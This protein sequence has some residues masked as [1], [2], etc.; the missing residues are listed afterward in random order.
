MSASERAMVYVVRHGE[1]EWSRTGRH[2]GRSDVVLTPHG[3]EQASAIGQ[4]LAGISFDTVLTS[5][6]ARAKETCRTA[7]Y[8]GEAQE[9]E[10]LVEWDY[11]D[12]EG[13]TTD[14]IRRSVPGWTLFD[15]GVIGGESPADVGR[16][17]DRVIAVL[18]ERDGDSLCFAHAHVLRVFAARWLG[19][20]PVGGKLLKLGPGS[21]SVLGWEREAP[22]ISSWNQAPL[23]DVP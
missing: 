9:C 8:L 3:E 18:R 1:T 20:P 21:V 13:L 12:Y 5:P 2:T 7:G 10:D 14:E 4:A 11:G 6:L 22:V 19:L 15:H 23:L 17:V 16:R